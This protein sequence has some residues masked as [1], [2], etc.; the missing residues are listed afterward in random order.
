VRLPRVAIAS[1]AAAALLVGGGSWLALYRADHDPRY[2]SVASIADEPVYQDTALVERAWAL[3]VAKL[4][5]DDGYEYQANPSFCGPTSAANVAQSL[6]KAVDQSS[7]LRGTVVKP[8]LGFVP[9]VTLDQE[10][11]ILRVATGARVSVLRDLD[12]ATFRA[13]LRQT[14]D[15]TLRYVINFSRAPLWGAGH[16]HISPVL[17]YLPEEDLVFIGDANS[18]FKPFLVSSARLL[19]AMNTID[20]STGKSRGLLRVGPVTP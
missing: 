1:A 6:G 5:R 10:A 7:V 13:H 16:G 11:D 20:D 8:V 19:E 18:G 17:G 2:A 12:L 15:P 14:N 3:P 4:Y 9:G